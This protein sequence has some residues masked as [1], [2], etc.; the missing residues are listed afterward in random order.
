MTTE[1]L[2]EDQKTSGNEQGDSNTNTTSNTSSLDTLL[3]GIKN[4]R[5]EQKY[6]SV[7]EALKGLAHA[8][9]LI[10][11]IKTEKSQLEQEIAALREK[12]QKVDTLEQTIMELTQRGKKE[13]TPPTQFGEEDIA[14]IVEKQ[15]T[16]RQAGEQVERN[17][18]SVKNALV[19]QFGQEQAAV[20]FQKKAEELEITP[21][22]LTSLVGSSPKAVL[23]M[24][25]VSESPVKNK[26][27][28]APVNGSVRTD[29]F[30]G[31]PASL[32]G[33]KEAFK[34]PSG[35]TSQDVANLKQKSDQLL[36]ELEASGIS[37]D[38]LTNPSVYFKIF[39]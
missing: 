18:A 31:K 3:A 12:T 29:G 23:A 9:A 6:S 5:G 25:G 15:I 28:K 13:E 7:E 26:G 35:A 22:A 19:A 30:Q 2:F 20:I 1:N 24:F 38:D 39:G 16:A 17:K 37:V 33:N 34:L 10:P 21:E 36:E 8:Q 14:K 27:T 4:E 32:I 11:S